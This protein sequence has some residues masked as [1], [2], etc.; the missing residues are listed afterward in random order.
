MANRKLNHI[1]A[2][3][4]AVP[5]LLAYLASTPREFNLGSVLLLALAITGIVMLV[6]KLITKH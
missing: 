2:L 1:N 4:Y 3:K 6:L 5:I